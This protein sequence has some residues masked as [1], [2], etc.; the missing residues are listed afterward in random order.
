MLKN[1]FNISLDTKM[2]DS[3]KNNPLCLMLPK[4]SAYRTDYD[5]SNYMPF[6]LNNNKL[7]EKY[8]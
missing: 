1:V 5:E 3:G 6:W 4:M 8:S 2:K 7:L